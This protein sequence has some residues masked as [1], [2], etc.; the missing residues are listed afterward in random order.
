M[1]NKKLDVL[2][3]LQK[4]TQHGK[5]QQKFLLHLAILY[6]ALNLIFMN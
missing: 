4:K 5:Q 3:Y 2:D 1:T 6:A